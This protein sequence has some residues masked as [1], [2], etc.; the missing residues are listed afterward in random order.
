VTF[1]Q[2]TLVICDFIDLKTLGFVG[3]VMKIIFN[4]I[5]IANALFSFS[6]KKI[7]VDFK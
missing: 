2:I 3:I 5:D 7:V 4:T 6:M 1:F